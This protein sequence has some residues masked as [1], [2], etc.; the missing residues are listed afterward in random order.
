MLFITTREP[1]FSD[2]VT[3]IDIHLDDEAAVLDTVAEKFP[4]Q[5]TVND[6]RSAEK[7]LWLLSGGVLLRNHDDQLA[8]GLRDCN[9]ADPLTFTNIAAGRCDRKLYDHSLEELTSELVLCVKK[10]QETWIQLTPGPDSPKIHELHLPMVKHALDNLRQ[11]LEKSGNKS[12]T[13]PYESYQDDT[14][15][16]FH[17]LN[18]RWF[19]KVNRMIC[20]ESLAGYVL[21]DNEHHST[22]FRLPL[23]IDLSMYSEHV[24]FFAEGSGYAE[25]MSFAQIHDLYLAERQA[26]RRFLTPFL[27]SF[28]AEIRYPAFL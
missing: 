7:Q 6:L 15:A 28:I 12:E 26:K 5:Q 17:Q 11:R 8:I 13:I 2:H 9:G 23:K 10:D 18:V 21:I 19:D 16:L 27:R 22:E 3:I 25:W 20:T 4:F 24:I 1:K 14:H